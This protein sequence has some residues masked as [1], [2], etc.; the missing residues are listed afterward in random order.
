M[1]FETL[2]HPITLLCHLF[3]NYELIEFKK[4]EWVRSDK[5]NPLNVTGAYI[6]GRHNDS[7]F[8]I[9]LDK[10]QEKVKKRG[11]NIDYEN[12]NI[13]LNLDNN[14]CMI[15]SKNNEKTT[16]SIDERF[17]E[18]YEVQMIL[19]DKFI[20]NQST[21]R[22]YRY[23]DYPSQINILNFLY[24]ELFIKFVDDEQFQIEM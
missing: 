14:T 20:Q 6:E 21:W 23:D 22:A 19:L 13:N 10:S 2:I 16:I 9:N 5:K 15:T 18:K 11:M 3:D 8:K 17:S 1:I 12:G 7:I 4:I 24:D